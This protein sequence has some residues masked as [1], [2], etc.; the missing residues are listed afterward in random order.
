MD[1]SKVAIVSTVANFDLYQKSSKLF[2]E[3]AQK[4]IIDGR[5]GMH[6]IHSLLYMFKKL[7]DSDIKWL[8]MADEDV[9]F[10]RPELV[11]DMIEKMNEEG[12]AVSGVRDGGMVSHRRYNPHVINTFFSIMDFELIRDQWDRKAVLRNQVSRPDEFH[13]DLSACRYEYDTES[14]LEPYYCFYLWLRRKDMK[15]L[16]LDSEMEPDGISNSVFFKGEKV[17]TH[18]WYARVYGL[19]E[20]HTNRINLQLEKFLSDDAQVNT[21][22]PVIY[23]SQTFAARQAILKFIRK[24]KMKLGAR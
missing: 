24:V 4:I 5:N 18:T 12:I 15:M 8:I 1:K 16:F 3:G 11:F 2:P 19:S 22:K 23:K 10:Y 6:G 9:I 17:F 13:D 14:L 20:K 21:L 7:R